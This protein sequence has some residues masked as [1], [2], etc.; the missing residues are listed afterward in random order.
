MVKSLGE[1]LTR[2]VKTNSNRLCWNLAVT[3]RAW[4]LPRNRDFARR[5]EMF[6]IVLNPMPVQHAERHTESW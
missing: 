1:L 3:Q 2:L 6:T 5:I 4:V